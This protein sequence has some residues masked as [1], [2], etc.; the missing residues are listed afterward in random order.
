MKHPH[1][2][3]IILSK[4]QAREERQEQRREESKKQAR[5]ERQK[6]PREESQE[7]SNRI[8]RKYTFNMNWLEPSHPD[9]K[10]WMDKSTIVG[11]DNLEYVFCKLCLR[12]VNITCRNIY[13]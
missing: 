8:P 3:Y 11:E 13:G 4:E 10:E 6:K 9:H 7:H 12:N 1:F 2:D 5:K